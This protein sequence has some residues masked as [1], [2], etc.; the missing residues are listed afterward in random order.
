MTEHELA[1]IDAA[2]RAVPDVGAVTISVADPATA[3]E[4]DCTGAGERRAGRGGGEAGG[5]RAARR[6]RGARPGR[7]L[8]RPSASTPSGSTS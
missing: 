7:G 4:R 2:V 8:P 1:T 3:G 6:R 5:A